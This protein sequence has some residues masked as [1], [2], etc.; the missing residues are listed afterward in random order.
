MD[1]AD[2]S[3]SLATVST[4]F[5]WV[6]STARFLNSS[7]YLGLRFFCI[8]LTSLSHSRCLQN[9]D[10]FRV[11][12]AYPAVTNSLGQV[13]YFYDA[14]GRMEKIVYPTGLE[15]RFDT[16]GGTPQSGWDEIGQLL[17]VRYVKSDGTLLRSFAYQYDD[18]GNRTSAIESNGNPA[19]EVVWE[20]RYDWFDRLVQVKRGVGGATPSLQR[21]YTYDESDNR[22]YVDDVPNNRT[23]WY[24]YK[25]VGSG[26]DLKYSDEIAEVQVASGTG[27]RMPADQADFSVLESIVSDADGN[28]TSR[29]TAGD[30]TT[31]EWD[32][33]NNLVKVTLPDNTV[34]EH[35]YNPNHIREEKK[36]DGD[37]FTTGILGVNETD[38]DGTKRS[39]IL[40]HQVLGYR[41]NGNFFFYIRDG[42]GSVRAILDSSYQEVESFD[43][44]EF[45]NPLGLTPSSSK[46]YVGGLG[47]HNDLNETNLLYMQRRH[48]APD[49]G[50]FI[51]PDP[52][53][54][55][56]GS[57][58][59]SYGMNNPVTYT[60]HTGLQPGFP[61]PPS[62]NTSPGSKEGINLQRY[63]PFATLQDMVDAEK[64]LPPDIGNRDFPPGIMRF[65]YYSSVFEKA[66]FGRCPCP[67]GTT[68]VGKYAKAHSAPLSLDTVRAI[69]SYPSSYI[70]EEDRQTGRVLSV[71]YVTCKCRT[72]CGEV[73]EVPFE[74]MGH[75]PNSLEFKNPLGIPLI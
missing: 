2:I 43:F 48:Y 35:E 33:Y 67:S 45:G 42:L 74:V 10:H 59:F 53:G 62:P 70:G 30:T 52:I 56:G 41:E 24:S 17:Q 1:E 63:L 8:S 36:T 23:L 57:N 60:D 14:A 65:A 7:L 13:E 75:Q 40:G 9:G 39:Y 71:H 26:L 34:T 18:S 58:L 3:N 5:S 19:Q 28:I 27:K 64:A 25:T 6:N 31:Y 66:G 68:P 29:T 4:P 61:V 69:R 44:D 47:V 15:A 38:F 37:T 72:E 21:E 54:L 16:G 12:V 55:A 20:Y 32:D 22:V 11:L 46:T 73:I 51:S 50:R 49:L